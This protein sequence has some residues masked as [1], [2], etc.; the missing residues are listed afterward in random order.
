MET[1]FDTATPTECITHDFATQGRVPNGNFLFF[2]GTGTAY[3]GAA[4]PSPS[5]T[6]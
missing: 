3:I 5:K 4:G 1:V 6:K 2:R